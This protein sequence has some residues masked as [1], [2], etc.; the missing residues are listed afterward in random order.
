VDVAVEPH[1]VV[2]RRL[3]RDV[4]EAVEL[5]R[6]EPSSTPARAGVGGGVAATI[7]REPD[8]RQLLLVAADPDRGDGDV[9][10]RPGRDRLTGSL[11]ES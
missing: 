9:H 11:G 10:D 7:E 4:L 2:D 6:A 1:R 5:D 3:G 8:R